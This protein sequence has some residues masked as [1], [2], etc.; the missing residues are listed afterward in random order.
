MN[1][2]TLLRQCIHQLEAAHAEAVME[3]GALSQQASDIAELK[4][5]VT[6][7]TVQ[8]VVAV[9]EDIKHPPGDYRYT[10]CG[11]D[12]V[13]LVNGF[14]YVE[15]PR[16]LQIVIDDIDGLH[17]AIG[18]YLITLR[19][20]LSGKEIKFLRQEMLMSQSTLARLLGVSDRA[21]IRWERGRSGQVPPLAEATIRMLYRDFVNDDDSGPGTMRKMLKKIAELENEIQRLALRKTGNARWEAEPAG[22]DERQLDLGV[23]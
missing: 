10:E 2:A 11:L 19:K 9:K 5:T 16:G 23:R 6:G 20:N 4:H 12:N 7:R 18:E 13:Y 17:R 15:G 14:K 21:V 3:Y 8:V 1:T 22:Y